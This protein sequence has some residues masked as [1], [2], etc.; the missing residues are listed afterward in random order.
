MKRKI[1]SLVILAYSICLFADGVQPIGS[2]T[3]VD[4]YQVEI[5]DNLLWISTNNI[6]WDKH[7]I[8]TTDIDASD[9]QNWNNGEGFSPIGIDYD[10][11]FTGSY[12]GEDHIINYLHIVLPDNDCIG[13]F[14]Y[15]EESTISNLGLENLDVTGN[16][17]V[18]G[19]VGWNDNSMILNCYS[20]GCIIGE[21]EVGGLVGYNHYST[22]SNSY[23]TGSVTGDNLVGGLVGFNND[24]STI[25]NCYSISSLTGN[26]EIGGLTGCNEYSTISNSYSTCNIIGYHCIGGLVGV[27]YESLISNCYSNGSVTEGNDCVGGLVGFN[28]S[29]TIAN[30]Y[31]TTSVIGN[32]YTGGLI[33]YIDYP[34]VQNSFWDIQTSG[35]T[36]SAGGTGKTTAEM[37]DIATYTSL[38]TVGLE[39]SWDFVD[40]PFDDTGNEDF[41]NMDGINN[42]GYPFL[43]WQQFPFPLAAYFT[44]DQVCTNQGYPI[45]FT[46]L[47]TGSPISWYWDFDD[48]G[49]I[50]SE[51]QNP[52]WI[53]ED[54]GVYTISLT[55]EDE[56][57]S[58]ISIKE[59]YIM[60]I[61][62]IQPIGNGS[63]Q[64]PYLIAELGNLVWISSTPDSWDK[65]FIQTSDID[66]S[67]TQDWYEGKGFP[68]IGT[69]IQGSFSG[70]YNGQNHTIDNLF[71]NRPETSFQGLFGFAHFATIENIGVTNVTVN[72]SISCGGLVGR[73]QS[74]IIRNC[75]ST[76]F[77]SGESS[78][79]GLIGHNHIDAFINN[80]YSTASVSGSAAGGLVGYNQCNSTI[81]NSYSRGSVEGVNGLGGLVGYNGGDLNSSSYIDNC[82][83]TSSVNGTGTS[84][85]GLV[86][87]N[88]YGML[89]TNSFWDTES[90]GI[91]ISAGGTGKTT[92]EMQNVATYTSLSTLGLDFPWD[93]VG[94]PFDDT[95]DE[96][97]WDIDEEN[98]DGYPFLT[99]LPTVGI[100]DKV[101]TEIPAEAVLK[102]NYPNPFNPTTSISFSIPKESN[103]ELSVYNIKGQF[104]ETLMNEFKPVGEHSIVWDAGNKASGIYLYK[105]KAGEFEEIKKMVLMK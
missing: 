2:G 51:E 33:G 49:S 56:V 90:S 48:D 73:S 64:S 30:S 83:S 89:A 101:I 94:N 36:T 57:E 81:S 92:L 84:I 15:T 60:I 66:A 102:G 79:G 85:G 95:G 87:G 86:G 54:P 13:F 41:W 1:I 68:A 58:S 37:Q 69:S 96:D 32:G 16:Q 104:V 26:D 97:I 21:Q 23:S 100:D 29:S 27:C 20:I 76:G 40:N 59:N 52:E 44:T 72:G 17:G 74:S 53:Y 77:V 80:C 28:L 9:T 46:D 42:D 65:Y 63:E 8:Q 47:S 22:I 45:Q 7:F 5:L 35:Q 11:T 43:G 38:V 82:Y 93:F 31:S 55:I 88:N 71:I 19:F 39:E 6:S 91:S 12:N 103:V 3:E 70:N 25:V 61:T 75:Y 78:V 98:N 67:S 10:N 50:D 62:N 14:G 99:T 18:G 34:N 4:P 105:L 24:A